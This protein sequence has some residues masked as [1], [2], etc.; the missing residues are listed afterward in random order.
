MLD[1]NSTPYAIVL[2]YDSTVEPFTTKLDTETSSAGFTLDDALRT[3]T[4]AGTTWT[5]NT[6][7]YSLLIRVNG[8]VG[9]A[10]NPPTGAPGITGTP[11]VG[12]TLTATAGDIADVDG[13]PDPFLTDTDTSFQWI[14]V[15][16][17]NTETDISGATASTYTL[18]AGDLGKKIKVKVTFT[19]DGNTAETLTSA[20]TA[21]VVAAHC[22]TS[23]TNELWCATLTVGTQ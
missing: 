1:G 15:A 17:D 13:L 5:A 6:L 7:G 9:A 4:K 19:D 11:T 10:N 2:S 12:Q 21:T 14:Q 16:T 3:A 22:N 18:L 20:A 23:N 8:A